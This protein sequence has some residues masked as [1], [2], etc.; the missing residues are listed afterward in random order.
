[1]QEGDCVLFKGHR[2]NDRVIRCCTRSEYNHVA[3]VIENDGEL[4]LFE[5]GGAG[6]GVCPLEFYIN[7]YYW[8][9]MK[10]RC[11]R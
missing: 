9:T 5:S 7:A 2:L 11:T 10:S 6:V 1:M 3:M 8:G 4:E